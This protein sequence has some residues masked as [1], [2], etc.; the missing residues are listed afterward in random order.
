MT[1]KTEEYKNLSKRL[2]DF[3]S[4]DKKYNVCMMGDS[5]SLKIKINP[6]LTAS[7]F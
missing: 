3:I 4:N 2:Y 6:K 5:S 1:K 7:A